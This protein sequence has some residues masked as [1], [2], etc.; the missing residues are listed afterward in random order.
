MNA[1]GHAAV[2][3]GAANLR[4]FPITAGT[5]EPAI[6]DNLRLAAVDPVII[7]KWWSALD[8]NI[9]LACGARSDV[10]AVDVDADKTRAARRRS[11]SSRAS[12]ARSR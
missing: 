12:M 10:W 5:K 2:K 3:Y 4:V 9:G 8:F 11:P 1:K 7:E 6:K